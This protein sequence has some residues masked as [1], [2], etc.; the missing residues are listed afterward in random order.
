M[1]N[2]ERLV[3]AI[4]PAFESMEPTIDEAV[5]GRLVAAV[6]PLASDDFT[7]AMIALNVT[8]EFEGV[9]GIGS[10]WGDWLSVYDQLR[11]RIESFREVGENVLMEAMQVGVTRHDAVE[12]EQPSAAVWKFRAGELYRVEFHLD[13]RAAERSAQ[14]GQE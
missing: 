6:E 2:L 10:A 13:R 1:S 7:C 11:F 5:V 8:Q 12:I 9:E 4:G 14:S 3:E